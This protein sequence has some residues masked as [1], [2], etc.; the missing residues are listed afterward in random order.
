MENHGR[1]V[2]VIGAGPSGLAAARYLKAHG[3][4]PVIYEAADRVG[5]QWN[6]GADNSGVWPAMHA[7]SSRVVTRFS[8]LDYPAETGAFPAGADVLAYLERYVE[9]FGLAE[10]LRLGVRVETLARHPTGAWAVHS[11][12]SGM[13]P[14][15]EI[16]SRVVV[17]AGRFNR[18][19]QPDVPGLGGFAGSGGGIH[20]FDYEGPEPFAGKTVLVAGCSISALEIA[21]ELAR[22]GAK[23]VSTMRR[24]RYVVKKLVQG[25]PVDNLALTRFAA[26]ADECLPQD[27]LAAELKDFIVQTSG[28]PAA[29]G[30]LTPA[31]N[32]FAAGITLNEHFLDLV[33]AGRIVARPWIEAVAGRTACF[34]DGST[35]EIDAIVFGTGFKPELPF[36]DVKSR[37]VLGL[38]LN[39]ESLDLCD[40]TFHPDLDGLAF[41][42]MYD[43]TAPYFP[44]LELQARW[45]A[46]VWAGL[47]PAPSADAM[48]SS[49]ASQAAPGGA[50]GKPL[51]QEMALLF[52]RRAG[53]EP[54]LADWPGLAR[55]LLFGPLSP[56]SFR[57]SGPDAISG[58]AWEVVTEAARL[59]AIT[60]PVL[61]EVER[62]Q[63]QALV[64]AGKPELAWLAAEPPLE[65]ERRAA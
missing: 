44:T 35:A 33:S 49:I 10:N 22:S 11:I 23:V 36:L 56:V 30:A 64:A 19:A 41:V 50:T 16:F 61:T 54:N 65:A 7:N 8:D 12:Q 1:R 37:N 21:S 53:V 29:C 32:V 57:L 2:A 31:E 24:Q 9:A 18:P 58:A 46:Y 40:F 43:L 28:D 26:L 63:I 59:G 20:S 15:T 17:A 52:A 14:R 27:E 6:A 25:V 3:F 45:V 38:G 4:D 39:G 42:G 60:A 13:P 51:M 5:G 62:E 55:A 48:R 34:A 47:A